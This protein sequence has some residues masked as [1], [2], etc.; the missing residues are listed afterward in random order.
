MGEGR[1]E[2]RSF[3]GINLFFRLG[4]GSFLQITKILSHSHPSSPS[5][6]SFHPE[7][8]LDWSILRYILLDNPDPLLHHLPFESRLSSLLVDPSLSSSNLSNLSLSQRESQTQNHP[9]PSSLLQHHLPH[10]VS[11]GF[12]ELAFQAKCGDSLHFRKW[13]VYMA[14]TGGEGLVL[15]EPESAYTQGRTQALRT[16]K[17]T[18]DAYARIVAVVREEEVMRDDDAHVYVCVLGDGAFIE[19]TAQGDA[20]LDLRVGDVVCF[21]YT[22]L[23]P[24]TGI[25]VLPEM[26]LFFSSLLLSSL[27]FSFFLFSPLLSFFCFCFCFDVNNISCAA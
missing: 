14:E 26:Y 7:P 4:R 20:E 11:L 17:T 25:P 24:Q 21:R 2:R 16:A 3:Q 8:L 12:C 22:R 19:C 13:Q 18:R 9:P 23:N 27:F 15:R 10:V 6:P 1:G 5:T